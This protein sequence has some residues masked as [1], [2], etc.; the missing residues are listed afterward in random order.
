MLVQGD[1]KVTDLLTRSPCLLVYSSQKGLAAH[2]AHGQ[3]RFNF[4][5]INAI[6][7]QMNKNLRLAESKW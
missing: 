4:C 7:T 2:V 6:L 1:D 5:Y 3:K